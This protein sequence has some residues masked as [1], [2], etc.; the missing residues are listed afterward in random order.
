MLITDIGQHNAEEIN[1]GVAGAD[2][3]WPEREGTFL[4]NP[5]SD[6]SVVYPLPPDDSTSGYSY[7]VA[8]Y[9]HDEGSAISGG[10]VY[11]GTVLPLL[12]G[13]YVFG[14]IVNGRV[15]FVNNNELKPRTQALVQEF[16]IEVDGGTARPGLAL[17]QVTTFQQLCSSKKTDLR[18]GIGQNQDLYLFTKSDGRLY[19]VTDCYQPQ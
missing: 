15:F 17:R 14:D 4:L 1:L 19:R 9:D 16:E 6:M 11:T 7:P 2:Y 12:S 5:R 3:G 8:Q 13:K 18:F 10:F